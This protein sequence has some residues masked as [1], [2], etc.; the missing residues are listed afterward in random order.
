MQGGRLHVCGQFAPQEV[1][2]VLVF[3]LDA[4]DRFLGPDE[5][6]ADGHAF[7]HFVDA[8]AED[9]FVLMEE[10]FALGGVQQQGVGACGEFDVGGK[11]GP[12]GPDHARTGNVFDRDVR[13]GKLDKRRRFYR[14]SLSSIAEILCIVAGTA[15]NSP[16]LPS[17]EGRGEGTRAEI[18]IWTPVDAVGGAL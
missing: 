10:R 16:P 13:H 8:F 6:H 1:D 7:D 5:P 2:D 3:L 11:A 4:D 18:M 12:A 15:R 9:F 17:G 14:T